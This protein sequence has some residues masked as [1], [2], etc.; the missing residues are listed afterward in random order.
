[1]AK[2]WGKT[3]KQKVVNFYQKLTSKKKQI[4]IATLFIFL[5]CVSW[6][7]AIAFSN[8]KIIASE[9][10]NVIPT[11]D[12]NFFLGAKKLNLENWGFPG[13]N[14]FST[15]ETFQKHSFEFFQ[16]ETPWGLTKTSRSKSTSP[17]FF[18][19]LIEKIS[20]AE[21]LRKK[22]VKLNFGEM[23]LAGIKMVNVKTFFLSGE[24]SKPNF[25]G[26]LESFELA[27]YSNPDLQS[28]SS[29]LF[30]YPEIKSV[31]GLEN[32]IS[33]DTGKG[34]IFGKISSHSGS[35]FSREIMIQQKIFGFNTL[36]NL[37]NA[38]R[39]Q[40]KISSS[41][42]RKDFDCVSRNKSDNSGKWVF[43]GKKRTMNIVLLDLSFEKIKFTKVK[44][45]KS[46][47]FSENKLGNLKKL[48]LALFKNEIF[49]EKGYNKFFKKDQSKKNLR[50]YEIFGF[51]N[52]KTPG[53]FKNKIRS[54]KRKNFG[55]IENKT[56]T[57]NSSLENH[58]GFSKEFSLIKK[59]NGINWKNQKR[60]FSFGLNN[61]KKIFKKFLISQT[62]KNWRPLSL[63]TK[64]TKLYKNFLIK[65]T[66]NKKLNKVI[67]AVS[68][69][70][71]KTQK[72]FCWEEEKKED[73]EISH[74]KESFKIKD[75]IGTEFLGIIFG[76]GSNFPKN[77]IESNKFLSQSSIMGNLDAQYNIGFSLLEGKGNPRQKKTSY[78][79][80][81]S[82]AKKGHM[83][84]IYDFSVLMEKGLGRKTDEIRAFYLN[85]Q[86]SELGGEE[87]LIS[88]KIFKKER[89]GLSQLFFSSLKK[90]NES[91]IMRCL[92]GPFFFGSMSFLSGIIFRK[93]G[94]IGAALN[95]ENKTISENG[96]NSTL[97]LVELFLE[98][99]Q[100]FLSVEKS[101]LSYGFIS[102]IKSLK[103]SNS[104]QGISRSLDTIIKLRSLNEI[105][106]NQSFL[107]FLVFR[108]LMLT[109]FEMKRIFAIFFR[110]I[111]EL[112]TGKGGNRFGLLIKCFFFSRFFFL[113]KST[114]Y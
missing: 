2:N 11:N 103:G 90:P 101:K 112:I 24:L 105:F 7:K 1:M 37:K 49:V 3:F 106:V 34:F 110:L 4:I 81:A 53:K 27:S 18:P 79:V 59:E 62:L 93:G 71:L 100:I 22:K 102:K 107:F 5:N 84:S 43:S 35:D 61:L 68:D 40:T 97:F 17:H 64:N 91:E 67:K 44:K 113:L 20:E 48:N 30:L 78:Q 98:N 80:L 83:D 77:F 94:K 52:K 89:V 6:R 75:P 14:F 109:F 55:K 50:I 58:I 26:I 95:H 72:K 36:K 54:L 69:E 29:C 10:E 57:F 21:K 32:R 19:D 13:I 66:D 51:K 87:K 104:L 86:I 96:F 16:K 111:I 15:I 88:K 92:V 99:R 31:Y 85:K 33:E 23:V 28:I 65:G 74:L 46:I 76:F 39:Y 12:K 82:G 114:N 63:N 45:N 47:T 9:S 70:I 108:T 25:S 56:I 41:T 8:F 73:S 38:F 42:L 60:V